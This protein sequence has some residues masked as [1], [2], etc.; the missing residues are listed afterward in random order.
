MNEIFQTVLVFI[1]FTA[2]LTYI[3]HRQKKSSWTGQVIDKKHYEAEFGKYQIG[4]RVEKKSG[5]YYPI[6]IN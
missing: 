5:D 3:S 6:K 1:G 4:D 2:V